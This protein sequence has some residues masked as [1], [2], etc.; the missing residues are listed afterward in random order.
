MLPFEAPLQ[1]TLNPPA[2]VGLLIVEVKTA[3]CVSVMPLTF[4][5][6]LASVTV[7]V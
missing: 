5:Q 6:L 4:V 7:T 2:T 3:G 1:V